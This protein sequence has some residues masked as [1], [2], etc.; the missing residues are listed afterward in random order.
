MG[1]EPAI[2]DFQAGSFNHGATPPAHDAQYPF[3]RRIDTVYDGR[4]EL[5]RINFG[6]PLMPVSKSGITARK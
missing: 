1:F 2:S 3:E 5:K 4:N 6:G